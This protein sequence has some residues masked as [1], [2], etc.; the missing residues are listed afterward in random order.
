MKDSEGRGCSS[1]FS[2]NSEIFTI[3]LLQ[4]GMNLKIF[5]SFQDI[6]VQKHEKLHVTEALKN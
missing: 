2:I 1:S 5:F 6:K 4:V 3:S